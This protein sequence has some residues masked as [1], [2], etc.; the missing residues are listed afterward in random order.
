MKKKVLVLGIAVVMA[1]SMAFVASCGKTDPNVGKY[2]MVEMMGMTIDD[3]N[4]LAGEDVSDMITLELKDGGKGVMKVESES[5][6][7]EWKVDGEKISLTADGETIEGTIKD[8]VIEI[9]IDGIS[10]VFEKEKSK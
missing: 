3:M 1:L 4:K 10:V 9:E 8:G 6:D 5:G 7:V 2:K